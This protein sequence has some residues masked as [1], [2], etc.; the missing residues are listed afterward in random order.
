V[1]AT[2]LEK[3]PALTVTLPSDREIA[4]TRVFD[5]PR[6]LVFEACSRPEHV[7]RWWGPRGSTLTVCE[8]DFRPG[9]AWRFVLRGEDGR[10]HPFKGVYREVVP[11]ER[12]VATFIYDVDFI[13]D[14]PALETVTFEE[15][16]GRTTLRINVLHQSKEARD[17]HLH[18]GMESGAN[19][20][21]D[22]L[23][24]FLRTMA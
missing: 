14:S 17:G 16:D 4:M 15:H 12:V 5:A 20:S 8:M 18:S 22:R 7:A 11:P 9:G 10:D 2:S 6:R 24:E 3:R 13:R 21:Y 19:Q 23:A 1:A